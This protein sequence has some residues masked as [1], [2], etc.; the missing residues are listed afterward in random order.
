M[1]AETA[2]L[3]AV[4]TDNRAWYDAD[5]RGDDFESPSLGIVWT[6]IGQVVARGGSV[7][8]HSIAGHFGAWGVRGVD[9]LAA[10]DWVTDGGLTPFLA[11][12]YADT[13]RQAATRRLGR[14]VMSAA[15]Q[16]LQDGADPDAVLTDVTRRFVDGT[17]KAERSQGGTLGDILAMED[18]YDW[19]VP[20]LLES[21]DRLILTGSEGLGKSTMARQLL[22]LP[23][24]GI[25][26]FTFEPIEP[27]RSLVIDAE[28]TGRQW[29]RNSGWMRN[30]ALQRSGLDPNDMVWIETLGRLNLLDPRDVGSI[31]R[32]IDRWKPK[33]MFI[34]PLYRLAVKFNSDE[35]AAPIIAALDEFR[36]RGIALVMEAHTG[37]ALGS[38]GV[39][40]V[41]PR[42]SSA[43]MGWP[44]FGFGIRP[45][46]DDRTLVD[47]VPWRGA[48]EHRKF[49]ETFRRGHRSPEYP[50]HAEFP[51][52]PQSWAQ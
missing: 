47:F 39:R 4:L 33:V 6:G 36:D 41:R 35:D 14:E 15:M 27:V 45:N 19:V 23:A 20:D 11:A 24:A 9:P 50:Q 44:E 40:D 46:Q 51:W 37:H 2:L 42:G 30:L 28:N 34:G 29:K 16:Q 22:I 10:H 26:P 25:H 13:I 7:D 52:I 17:A 8:V 18:S 32:H 31:H 5:V 1:S 38:G 21:K 12:A 43:L 48:R 3:G 49:P